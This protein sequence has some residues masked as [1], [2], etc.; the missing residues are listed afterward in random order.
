MPMPA[1]APTGRERAPA[2]KGRGA[3]AGG[4]MSAAAAATALGPDARPGAPKPKRQPRNPLPEGAPPVK[5]LHIKKVAID[6]D[7]DQEGKLLRPLG[8]GKG[9]NWQQKAKAAAPKREPRRKRA[10]EFVQAIESQAVPEPP[11]KRGKGRGGTKKTI[12][13]QKA[14][15]VISEPKR[16]SAPKRARRPNN[17]GPAAVAA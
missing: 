10:V 8:K 15:Q 12:D 9:A 6:D 11:P 4:K 7:A 13:V 2:R 14:V 16:K 17:M 1:G 5:K 3:Q